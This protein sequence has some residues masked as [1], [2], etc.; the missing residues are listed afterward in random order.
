MTQN[1]IGFCSLTE[2]V[3]RF[4]RSRDMFEAS[5]MSCLEAV[6]RPETREDSFERWRACLSELIEVRR[7]ESTPIGFRGK[8]TLRRLPNA[9][10][11]ETESVAQV[12]EQSRM[13][14]RRNGTEHLS[15]NV[16]VKGHIKGVYG[17]NSLDAKQHDVF[18]CDGTRPSARIY[19]PFNVVSLYIPRASA[20]QVFTK[21]NCSGTVFANSAGISRLLQSHIRGLAAYHDCMASEEMIAAAQAAF[22]IA[23]GALQAKYSLEPEHQSALDRTIKNIVSEY[24]DENLTDP[25]LSADG[26]CAKLRVSRSRL[27]RLFE[28]EGGVSRYIFDCRLD[29]CFDYL[30]YGLSKDSS[31]GQLALDHGFKSEAHFSRAF[32]HR[33]D[34]SPRDARSLIQR[35]RNGQAPPT[36]ETS[37]EATMLHWFRTTLSR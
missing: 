4:V 27:Y 36:P 11:L 34:M 13:H 6:F 21:R 1:P 33:F 2:V 37:R 17:G 25:A 3:E 31:I 9:L 22:L 20:P 16:I 32:R 5:K 7:L 29:R 26:V 24:I 23:A 28:A 18:L 30:K 14:I 12:I 10:I 15:I 8:I 19:S 35:T